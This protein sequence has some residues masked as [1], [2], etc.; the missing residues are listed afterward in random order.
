MGLSQP[1]L[2]G[3]DFYD[4]WTELF[5]R[6]FGPVLQAGMVRT[7][8]PPR[9]DPTG[10]IL[11]LAERAGVLDGDR[12]LD[13]GCGV[14]GPATIIAAHHRRVVIDAV[15]NSARQAAIARRRVAETGLGSRVRVHVGDYQALPFPA[16]VFDRILFFESTGYATDL[17]ATYR[18]AFR[19]LKG[20][21]GLYVKDVFCR[22]GPLDAAEAMALVQFDQVWGC[23]RSKTIGE[24]MEAMTAAGF[25]V[26]L[27]AAM[28]E[29][30][31]ARLAG[32]MLS[33]DGGGLG[34]SEMGR[35]F[36]RR[37]L[38]APIEFGEILAVKPG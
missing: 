17:V 37:D 14:A 36:L 30:G 6:G 12:V 2:T 35:S 33:L 28:P 26:L 31:T 15:T 9:E 8:D 10:S 27:A 1:S 38:R 20:S 13:A 23:A 3:A 25:D 34:L 11:A 22:P 19:V 7:G 24:S 5:L 32:S 18:E 16:G 29:M 21:G 4:R